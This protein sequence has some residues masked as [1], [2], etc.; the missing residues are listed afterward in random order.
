MDKPLTIWYCDVCQERIENFKSGY[1][2][3]R[4]TDQ[5]KAHDFKIIHQ[6]RCDRKDFPASAALEDFLG[7]DGLSY[8]LSFL[9]LGPVKKRLSEKPFF[10]VKDADEFVDFF[11]RLQ[12]PYYEEARRL[13]GNEDYLDQN[14]DNNEVSP[15]LPD[16]PKKTIMEYRTDR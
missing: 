11:R 6:T 10:G 13:F 9:S 16:V 4:A 12:V 8:L 14:S 2:I 1:V 5:M 15:Y 7:A 3:W